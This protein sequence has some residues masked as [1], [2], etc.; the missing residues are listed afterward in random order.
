[1]SHVTDRHQR[2]TCSPRQFISTGQILLFQQFEIRTLITWTDIYMYVTLYENKEDGA[3]NPW[4]HIRNCLKSLYYRRFSR[5]V[6]WTINIITPYSNLKT[7]ISSFSFLTSSKR[8]FDLILLL[9][10]GIVKPINLLHVFQNC[11]HC[12]LLI[13]SSTFSWIGAM[14]LV[15]HSNYCVLLS[16]Y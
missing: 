16:F 14:H 3:C 4:F 6:Y 8:K 9:G 7:R 13:N 10:M 15:S 1:M 5:K 2:H 12:Y 11:W